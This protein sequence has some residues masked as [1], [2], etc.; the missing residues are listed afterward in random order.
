MLGI[1]LSTL[2]V[3]EL[4]RLLAVAEQRGQDALAEQIRAELAARG[5]RGAPRRRR[6]ADEDPAFE[7]EPMRLPEAELPEVA[8]ERRPAPRR[9][10]GLGGIV[11]VGGV[12]AAAAAWA[13]AGAPG[14]PAKTP[15][16]ARLAA[17][18]EAPR[19]MTARVQPPPVAPPPPAP[20][21]TPEPIVAARPEPPPE[22]PPRR[23]DP[24]AQPGSPADGLVCRDLA[25]QLLA[26]E[27]TVAYGRA[28]SAG[29][30]PA[31]LRRAQAAWRQARDPV[32]NPQA[33][34]RLYDQR[35]R[36]LKGVVAAPALDEAPTAS[37]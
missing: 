36:D 10:T 1:D 35:I 37:P 25:L 4:R 23:L 5:P 26:H 6:P 29:A 2:G 16:P 21:P 14:L 27:L 9:R 18:A 34:A 22:T 15:P 32:T 17:A 7:P 3:A 20:A 13:L 8:F 24:C 12:A 31:E 11:A 19:A 33:L 28:L 30:D